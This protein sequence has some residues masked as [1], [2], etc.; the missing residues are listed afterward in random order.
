MRLD[1]L[2]PTFR[3]PHL[4]QRALESLTR[5]EPPRRLRVGITIINND[6]CPELPGLGTT[7]G[8]VPFATRVLHE[9]RPGKSVALNTAIAASTA[10]YL[11]FIDDDE[12][13][14]PNW[15]RVVEDALAAD[16]VD[17]LGG[18][19]LP[20]PG[21]EIPSWVP[22]EY[23]AVLGT[24][25]SGPVELAYGPGFP[26]MLKG[27]NA[28]ISRH[29]LDKVGPYSPELGPTAEQRLFSCEDE[30][31]YLR[32]VAAGASGRYLPD[33]IVYHCVHTDRLS[34]DYYRRWAFW[35]G[36]SKGVLDRRHPT[37]FRQIA[38][39]PRYAYGEATRGLL[40]WLRAKA[41]GGSARV[42]LTAELPIWN[43]VGRL[44]GRHVRRRRPFTWRHP[45]PEASS[46]KPLVLR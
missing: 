33:L 9:P 10:D 28:V 38:G 36:A 5:A 18:R 20:L 15:F 29:T 7:L 1:L 24:A 45:S 34:I 43:L 11:G 31:M 42:R 27:G 30:D 4:L 16:P 12:E 39:V 44:Y 22:L 6:V 35:Q 23:R 26:G 32:L 17:F 13:L 25:D 41:S 40:T 14:A 3:R 21:T 37:A 46:C 19:V 8:S 2:V